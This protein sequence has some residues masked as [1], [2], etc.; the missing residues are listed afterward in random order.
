MLLSMG[1]YIGGNMAKLKKDYS[2]D[3]FGNKYGSIVEVEEAQIQPKQWNPPNC[4]QKLTANHVRAIKSIKSN[5]ITI[6]NGPAGSLKTFLA[7]KCGVELLKNGYLDHYWYIRQNIYRPNEKQKG[8]LPGKESEKL[9]PLLAPVLDN[10]NAIMP[11]GEL[12]YFLDNQKIQCSDIDGV[13]GRSPL[14]CFIH[15]DEAQNVDL[16]GLLAVMTR[17]SFTSKLVITGDYTGQRDLNHRDFDA[18]EEV[19]NEFKDHPDFGVVHFNKS[20]IL[21]DTTLISITEGFDRIQGR[22]KALPP[23]PLERIALVAETMLTHTTTPL[24]NAN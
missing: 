14:N 9:S 1:L 4:F 19:C 13:R 3:N 15:C 21:R 20:D 11:P 12:K 22:R 8:A 17:K 2:T 16:A 5:P 7:L 24:Q 18:F 10:L 6:I 23:T